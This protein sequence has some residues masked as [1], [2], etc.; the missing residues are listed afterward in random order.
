VNVSKAGRFSGRF[1]AGFVLVAAVL[2]AL[3]SIVHTTRAPSH[4]NL[5]R[6]I[7]ARLVGYDYAPVRILRAGRATSEAVGADPI[8]D[9]RDRV[10]V[11]RSARNL[12]RLAAALLAS[13]EA[14]K[15]DELLLEASRLDPADLSIQSDLAA[16]ELALGKR[17]EAAERT[18]RLLQRDPASL[19]AAFNWA[20][21]L[22]QLS[23][24]SG[25][26]AAWERYLTLDNESPWATEA[27]EHLSRL[28]APRHR[29][30]SDRDAL[31]TAAPG[32]ESE[33]AVIR[34]YP[35]SA[36]AWVQG[37]LLPLWMAKSQ[38]A[39]YAK[40]QSIGQ[41]FLRLGEPFVLRLVEEAEHPS[42]SLRDG[43][44]IFAE[45]Q[46]AVRTRDYPGA[47]SLYQ[48]AA[49]RFAD[50]ESGMEWVCRAY[51]ASAYQNVNELEL[52]VPV[53]DEIQ[54]GIGTDARF[55]PVLAEAGMTR[56]LIL[57]RRG[58]WNGS[59][60]TFRAAETG[61]RQSG[62]RDLE[63]ELRVRIAAVLDRVAEPEEAEAYRVDVL[64]EL[65]GLNPGDDALYSAMAEATW[66]ALR[67]GRPFLAMAFIRPQRDIA[68]RSHDPLLLAESSGKLAL[69]ERDLGRLSE[70]GRHLSE[71]RRAAQAI[72]TPTLRDRT[73]ADMSYIAGT[74][75]ARSEPARAMAS[76]ATAIGI[77]DH[78]HL[79]NRSATAHLVRGNAAS[80]VGDLAAAE[81]DYRAGIAQ[82]ESE[83]QQLELPMRIAYFEHAGDLFSRLIELLLREGRPADA[84]SVAESERGRSL[85]DRRTGDRSAN[86]AVPM[87]AAAV[88]AMAPSAAIMELTL[89]DGGA[90]IW[91]V[92]GHD[93]WFARS[94]QPGGAIEASIERYLAAVNGH[95]D[96]AAEKEGRF[97]YQQ[98][99]APIAVH[100]H[101]SQPLVVVPDGALQSIPFA[102]L[103][104]PSGRYLVE[105]RAIA[106]APSATL[107][108]SAAS[109]THPAPTSVIAAA[110]PSPTGYDPLPEV[111]GEVRTIGR[112]YG[113]GKVS[114][115]SEIGPSQF[116]EAMRKADAAHF[117]GHAELDA[118]QPDRSAL[119]FESPAGGEP[120]MLTAAAIASSHFTSQ[121]L[122][123]LAACSTGRGKVRRTEGADS[124][125]RA[126]LHG[127]ARAVV[128]TLWDIEDH[129]SATLFRSLHRNLRK[130]LPPSEALRAAQLSMLHGD[131]PALRSPRF[132][133]GA[134]VIG[135]L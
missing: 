11:D 74:T 83:R 73:L 134:T 63:I 86:P 114:I 90:A 60:A 54:Q 80:A 124:L 25:A 29:W 118:S 100:L 39:D 132:W 58:D 19:P 71:G 62:E 23:I 125:A 117:G 56:A 22:E 67:A 70:V 51:Q 107:F 47:A 122:V 13:G 89:L 21:A 120:A 75:E 96:P 97:L 24:R 33:A 53:L 38:P 104:S 16:G 34:R 106:I 59:L 76:L 116:L 14:R 131:D 88:M 102:A 85:L 105:E 113:R 3:R 87:T 93:F 99:V 1:I 9:L 4:R 41:T 37:Y 77:W 109:S 35:H 81:A 40:L 112:L 12:H 2:L 115:G 128:A 8:T 129:A 111:A 95:D 92:S 68:E 55:R 50:A 126:F 98:L 72:K 44:R 52:A 64:R 79:R 30:L 6:A 20:L 31:T 57:L 94:G 27:R 66:A 49:S 42:D 65:D 17:M 28:R 121:P 82:M 101:P 103:A 78:Y 43:Y 36:R 135:S 7:A 123:I 45:A 15:A 110:E 48:E 133:G 130:G 61:A 69:A 32:S 119:I 91:L 84:L 10:L 108:L 18:G 5:P 127:G 26:I 46:A